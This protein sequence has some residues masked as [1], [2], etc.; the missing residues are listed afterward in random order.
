MGATYKLEE[1]Q[2]TSLERF[3]SF[4]NKDVYEKFKNTDLGEASINCI[5]SGVEEQM[6]AQNI[7]GY[8]ISDDALYRIFYREQTAQRAGSSRADMTDEEMLDEYAPSLSQKLSDLKDEW[9]IAINRAVDGLVQKYGPASNNPNDESYVGQ[10]GADRA[11]AIQETV[12][13][14]TL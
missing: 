1:L 9:S 14:H 11:K 7:E 5:K 6:Q 2:F 10:G 3:D 13:A 4:Y 8:E 12:N